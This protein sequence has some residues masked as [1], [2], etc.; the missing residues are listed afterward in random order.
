[1]KKLVIILVSV[2]IICLSV[3]ISGFMLRTESERL[4]KNLDGKIEETGY[5]EVEHLGSAK[6][7]ITDKD[8]IN[9][10]TQ[11]LC[12]LEVKKRHPYKEF[13]SD[14]TTWINPNKSAFFIKG[15]DEKNGNEL[16]D[17]TI[18]SN[19]YIE[20]NS[21]KYRIKTDTCIYDILDCYSQFTHS[22]GL[23]DITEENILEFNL[24]GEVEYAKEEFVT[25][26]EEV[27]GSK[28]ITKK[29]FEDSDSYISIKTLD[30]EFI[31]M[32]FVGDKIYTRYRKEKFEDE[33]FDRVREKYGEII[34][35]W[36]ID[37]YYVYE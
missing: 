34:S 31:D 13:I 29:E 25:K 11:E 26:Y 9:A 8:I 35:E 14:C 10:I 17:L 16:F 4:D 21:D 24:H 37:C 5:I 23:P 27:R 30:E 12:C 36:A 20:L 7:E 33:S 3:L 28:F 32:Y 1:M 6:N 19:D 22:V 2:S 18:N 15:Y